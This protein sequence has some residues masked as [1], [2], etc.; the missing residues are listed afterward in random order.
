M[1]C[2]FL[3]FIVCI[4]FRCLRLSTYNLFIISVLYQITLLLEK[5]E[6]GKWVNT[7]SRKGRR[8]R[9]HQFFERNLHIFKLFRP[10]FPFHFQLVFV[11][12][13]VILLHYYHLLLFQALLKSLAPF[14]RQSLWLI[15][16]IIKRNLSTWRTDHAVTRQAVEPHLRNSLHCANSLLVNSWHCGT[17]TKHCN[18]K[19]WLARSR[20][21][22]IFFSEM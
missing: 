20:E 10:Q 21:D 22:Y 3:Y 2:P 19:R 13:P 11:L 4:H 16:L 15:I 8:K 7:E 9:W 1:A 14:F 5:N 12:V 17:N 18:E 6:N